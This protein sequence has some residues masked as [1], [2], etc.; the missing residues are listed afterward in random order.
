MCRFNTPANS[1]HPNRS[2]SVRRRLRQRRASAKAQQVLGS[3][4]IDRRFQIMP[5]L[6]CRYHDVDLFSGHHHEKLIEIYFDSQK[7][8]SLW[9]NPTRTIWFCSSDKIDLLVR[10]FA[11]TACNAGYL[12]SGSHMEIDFKVRPSKEKMARFVR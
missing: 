2:K 9:E 5:P 8:R 6:V 11:I 3:V 7:C 10:A 12:K 4:V 1:P